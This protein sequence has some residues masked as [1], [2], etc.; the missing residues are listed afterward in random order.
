MTKIIPIDELPIDDNKYDLLQSHFKPLEDYKDFFI[1]M[2]KNRINH[3][4]KNLE[5]HIHEAVRCR[6]DNFIVWSDGYFSIPVWKNLQEALKIDITNWSPIIWEQVIRQM[7]REPERFDPVVWDIASE[8]M[9]TASLN[10][11]VESI[12]Y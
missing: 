10:D 4:E 9:L 7:A 8:M 3:C 1:Q 11:Y 5:L 6:F 2:V 12:P